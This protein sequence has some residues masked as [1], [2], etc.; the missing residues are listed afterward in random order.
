VPTA[1]P[2]YILQK[3][4]LIKVAQFS[5]IHHHISFQDPKFI[6]ISMTSPSEVQVT[7]MLL[8][9]TAANDAGVGYQVTITNRLQL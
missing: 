2:F 6:A 3:L 8:L 7:T 9:L 4:T 5:N 1:L